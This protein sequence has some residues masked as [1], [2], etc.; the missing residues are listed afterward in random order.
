[1]KEV[2]VYLTDEEYTELAGLAA[3][4]RRR[5]GQQLAYMVQARLP[6]LKMRR[7]EDTIV[8][9]NPDETH[10]LPVEKS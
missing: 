4:E 8:K 2:R 1:M 10:P 6:A 3:R 5:P 7:A 9:S